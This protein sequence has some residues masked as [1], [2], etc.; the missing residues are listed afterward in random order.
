VAFDDEDLAL[1]LSEAEEMVEVLE[2][3]LV[4]L[5]ADDRDAVNALFRAAHTLKGNSGMVGATHLAHF[6]HVLEGVLARVRDG[7]LVP[8]AAVVDALLPAVD[9]LRAVLAAIAAGEADPEVRDAEATVA[10]LAELC[11]AEKSDAGEAGLAPDVERRFRVKISV[12][13][14]E[15][16]ATLHALVDELAGYGTLAEVTPPIDTPDLRAVSFV[17]TATLRRGDIEGIVL[18]ANASLDLEGVSDAPVAPAA[19]AAE[20]HSAPSGDAAA[21]TQLAV[22]ASPTGE[23]AAAPARKPKAVAATSNFVKVDADRLDGLLDLVGELTIA[24][25]AARRAGARQG[26]AGRE[27]DDSL[28][29]LDRLGG[30][31]HERVMSLRMVTVGDTFERMRRPARDAAKQLDKEIVVETEGLDTELDRKL[32]EELVDPLTH[33]VR[34]SVAHGI[35]TPEAR[36]AAGKPRAGRIVLRA[37]RRNGVALI[38]VED[39]GGG[40]D[41]AK[42]K[43]QAVKRGLVAEGA[44]LTEKETYALLFAPGFSTAEAVN[45]VAGRGVGLDVVVKNVE[46]VRGRV[47]IVSRLGK[48]T[49][50]QIRLPLT[51]AVVDGMTVRVGRETMSIPL[52]E[53]EELLDASSAIRTLEGKAEYIDVRGEMLPLVRLRD[54][55]GLVAGDAAAK[56]GG[57]D[58]VLVKSDKR[59]FGLAVDDVLGMGKT[60]L[61]SLDRSMKVC[62]RASRTFVNP[63]AIGGA[64]ILDDGTV[65]YVLDVHGL[66]T[67]AFG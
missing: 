22:V 9:V 49:T 25:G 39:D 28:E 33:M 47:E 64:T 56:H 19:H 51:L 57:G 54:V 65:G 10:A 2:Q 23:P 32:L 15:P 34:N 63:L 13:D 43:R 6:T 18:F 26:G 55:L 35:E 53:V 16:A 11:D 59:R 36:V 5:D 66:D 1:F 38:E 50:F 62:K 21:A 14:G 52:R 37:Q 24:L 48:G 67:M 3:G 41:P 46:R 4:R 29:T 31:I 40:I 7:A 17:L 44:V 12:P 30:E 60:V 58:V 20:A 27:R 8:D 42:V 45:Q 61:K